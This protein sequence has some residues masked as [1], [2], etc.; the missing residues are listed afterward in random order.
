[1]GFHNVET[2]LNDGDV[3]I[4]NGVDKEG[5][6]LDVEVLLVVELLHLVVVMEGIATVILSTCKERACDR[7]ERSETWK[8]RYE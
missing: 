8:D 7:E 5:D 2:K 1:M 6:I 3:H 4:G